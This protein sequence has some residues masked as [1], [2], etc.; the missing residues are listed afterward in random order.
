MSGTGDRDEKR[1][2]LRV[3]VEWPVDCETEDTFLFAA[4]TNVSQM[5]IFVQ[6]EEPLEVGVVVSLKFAPPDAEAF[7]MK[8]RVQWVNLVRVFDDNPNPG[9][10]VMFIDLTLEERERLVEVIRTIAYVRETPVN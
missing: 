10:G 6:T 7:V 3:D 9:M 5:G 2:A 4:I 8:A 1:A